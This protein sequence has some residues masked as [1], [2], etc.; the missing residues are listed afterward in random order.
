M[1]LTGLIDAGKGTP[2]WDWFSVYFPETHGFTTKVNRELRGGPAS[3]PCVVPRPEGS[4]AQLVGT[5]VG[6]V[7]SA[8][9]K[10]GSLRNTVAGHG[11]AQIWA[12]LQRAGIAYDPEAMDGRIVL[13][14]DAMRAWER[15]LDE[16]EWCELAGL[17]VLLARFEQVGRAPLQALAHQ[18][19]IWR[20]HGMSRERLL[21]ALSTSADR[22]DVE[23][24]GR[25]A[26]ED[27]EDI[28]RA[29]RVELGPVF[30]QSG[31]LGGADADVIYDGV[32]LDF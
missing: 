15:K 22:Q 6:Y 4:N 23:A 20:E 26:V 14:I 24:L 18:V 5:A 7:L 12:E 11:G 2:L 13:R 21:D 19:P 16:D 3:T 10:E 8:C 27:H 25:T 17:C 1:S 9:L 29:K 31:A 28:R 32:L 30:D